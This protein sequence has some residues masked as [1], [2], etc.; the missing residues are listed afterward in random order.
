[1]RRMTLVV[2]VVALATGLTTAGAATGTTLTLTAPA[3]GALVFSKKTLVAKPGKVTIIL[4]NLGP[5]PHDIAIRGPKVIA[6]GKIVGKGKIST[7]RAILKKGR[8]VFFC[9]VPGHE[10]AGM[11]GT[12]IV[13]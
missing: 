3:S 5:L 9:T 8:Y 10:A 12:L 6:K 1:M 7:V 11:K 13:R 4:R 2:F